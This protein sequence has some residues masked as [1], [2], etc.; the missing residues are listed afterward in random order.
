MLQRAVGKGTSLLVPQTAA[1]N[2]AL[3]PEVSFVLVPK[4]A[5]SEVHPGSYTRTEVWAQ[6]WQRCRSVQEALQDTGSVA[7]CFCTLRNTPF[8]AS[9]L[10]LFPSVA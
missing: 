7:L 2:R 4:R 3:A 1:A 8:K 9:T 10:D 5:L 6:Y